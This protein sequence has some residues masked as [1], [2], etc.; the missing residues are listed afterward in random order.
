[1]LNP[2]MYHQVQFKAFKS[3]EICGVVK[4]PHSSPSKIL[5]R[6][7]ERISIFFRAESIFKRDFVETC[8]LQIRGFDVMPMVY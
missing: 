4:Q 1:M 2:R 5:I 3:Q 8:T 7:F 6:A